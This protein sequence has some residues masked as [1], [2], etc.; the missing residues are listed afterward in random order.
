MRVRHVVPAVQIIVHIH[1]PVALQCVNTPVEKLHLFRQFERGNDSWN[2]SEKV[3]KRPS[4]PVQIHKNK[5]LPSIHFHRHKPVLCA[6]EIAHALE[7]QHTLEHSI[8]SVRPAVIRTAEQPG[9]ACGLRHYRRRM[10]PANVIKR[11]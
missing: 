10:V 11:A 1:F 2:F 4:L 6:V 8:D 5:I 3:L 9:A 7:L